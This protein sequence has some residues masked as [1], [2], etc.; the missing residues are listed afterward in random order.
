MPWLCGR[1]PQ[2]SHPARQAGWTTE[3]AWSH[4]HRGLAVCGPHG[5]SQQSLR[6]GAT[7]LTGAP[8]VGLVTPHPGFQNA[9]HPPWKPPREAGGPA[10]C[11]VRGPGQGGAERA[12]APRRGPGPS[13]APTSPSAWAQRHQGP[14]QRGGSHGCSLW[15][16]GACHTLLE[17]RPTLTNLHNIHGPQA[18]G[19]CPLQRAGVLCPCW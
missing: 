8:L 13:C 7:L 3:L 9:S 10:W 1:P 18:T 14:A 12:L 2:R 16:R 4:C 17:I 11:R 6:C 15:K 5:P 19:K